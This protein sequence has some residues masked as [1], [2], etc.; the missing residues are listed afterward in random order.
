MNA[1]KQNLKIDEVNDVIFKALNSFYL[2]LFFEALSFWRE[3]QQSSS[4]PV[5]GDIILELS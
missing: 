2:V 4:M 1:E 5:V 3:F